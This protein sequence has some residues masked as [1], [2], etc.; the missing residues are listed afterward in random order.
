MTT[1]RK[2]QRLPPGGPA[3]EALRQKGQ[4]WTPAW[5]AGAMAAYVLRGGRDAVFDPAVGAGALLG[6]AK[7][8]AREIGRRISLSGTELDAETLGGAVNEG[9]SPEDLEHVEV[10]DFVFNPPAGPFGAV[11]A[12]PPYIRHHRL[13]APVK[14][15]LAALGTET[16]GRRLDGRA[17]LHVYFL[18]RALQL[19]AREGRLAFIM[20]ADTCEGVFSSALWH[21][22]TARY[23]LEAVV[24]FAPDASPFPGVDTNPVIFM[25]RNCEPR[26]SLFWARCTEAQTNELKEWVLSGFTRAPRRGMEVHERLVSEG[27]RVGLSRPPLEESRSGP[28]LGR[29][30]RVLRGIATGANGFF[31]L[32]RKEAAALRIPREFLLRAIG[33]TRDVAGDQVTPQMLRE[34]ESRGR[35]TLLFSPDG[36]PLDEFPAPVQDY[37][38]LGEAIG[39]HKRPLIATRSPWY[40]MEVREPPPI[41]FAYLGRRNA[42]FIRNLARVVPLTGF[43]CVYPRPADP[44][45]LEAL[46]LALSD[47]E[48]IGNLLFVGKSYGA[49]AIKVEPRALETLPIPASV[50]SKVGLPVG[51]EAEQISLFETYQYIREGEG[52][53]GEGGNSENVGR[54]GGQIAHQRRRKVGEGSPRRGHASAEA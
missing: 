42:R 41:L 22:I 25:I 28:P 43:L 46:W 35:P 21:W 24:T 8:V 3:R 44:R 50:A 15:K 49:G 17:G 37:L 23:R 52:Q 40:R 14:A 32:T 7:T 39:V 9:L 47:P 6:A 45:F 29:F 20:P 31:V 13:P 19:L 27:L 48:T 33:R 4:F 11:I 18:L 5:V 34:L 38:R 16:M 12:N 10:R 36:R 2:Q 54:G 53:Y 1:N 51:E 26:P 30:A